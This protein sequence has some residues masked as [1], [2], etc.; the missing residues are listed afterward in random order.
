MANR[1]KHYE[2]A[3]E[4][5]LH[6][7]R[8]PYIPI[9]ETK[10]SLLAGES[11]K[12]LDFIIRARPGSSWLIDVKGRRFPAANERRQYWKNWT[13]RD[14]LRALAA[15]ERLFGEGFQGLFVFAYAIVGDLSPLPAE[16]L[17]AFH[18]RWYAFVGVRLCDYACYARPI[19][20]AWQTVAL[21]SQRFREIARPLD[22]LFAVGPYEASCRESFHELPPLA[23][24]GGYGRKLASND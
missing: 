2:A 11:I 23:T 3:F 21:A 6:E 14:D 20:A 10:R 19:S 22:Q 7:R 5:Y 18:G 12:S 13:T 4:A 15:W 9:D 16:Q 17:Y 24:I 1:D 8:L